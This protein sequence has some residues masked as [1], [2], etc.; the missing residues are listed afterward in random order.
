MDCTT[1]RDNQDYV[2]L[3]P[4]P[5]A[6][7]A[8]RALGSGSVPCM[9]PGPDHIQDKSGPCTLE[10]DATLGITL[11]SDPH[12]LLPFKSTRTTSKEPKLITDFKSPKFSCC[13]IIVLSKK[14]QRTNLSSWAW[15]L[16]ELQLRLWTG[17]RVSS[18]PPRKACSS[19]MDDSHLLQPCGVVEQRGC[20]WP[21]EAQHRPWCLCGNESACQ[22]RRQG[23]DPW[24]GKIPWRRKCQPTPV[25]LPGESHGQRSLAG[26]SPWGH[27]ELDMT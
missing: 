11:A 5:Q 13:L 12:P 6:A 14:I 7:E 4:S 26:F 24:V 2:C 22:C 19:T 10:Q 18:D 17:E 8:L 9:S 23:L 20:T 3:G 1:T 21:T 15:C 16:W 25:F 27:K